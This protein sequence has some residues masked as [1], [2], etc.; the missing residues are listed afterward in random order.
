MISKILLGGLAASMVALGIVGWLLLSAKEAN[1]ILQQGID[2]AAGVN[3]RQ[4]ATLVE[5]QANH[6]NVMDQLKE[7]RIKTEAA[8]K[9]LA[10]SQEGLVSAKVDFDQRIKVALEGITDEERLRWRGLRMKSLS[11]LLSLCLLVLLTA[12]TTR[13][14]LSDPEI[15]Y[16]DKLVP[17]QV[18]GHLLAKCQVTPLPQT[19][20]LWTWFEILE[21]MKQK[22]SEQGACNER[23]SIIEDWQSSEP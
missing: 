16:Q 18:P 9:L 2:M 11:V 12:C 4:A 1:G 17:V 7:Q 19:G 23:F 10:L 6:D 15:V 8:T 22:D 3:A 14:V 21:L 20:S 5:V 13:T